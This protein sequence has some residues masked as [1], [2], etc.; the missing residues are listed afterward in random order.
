MYILYKKLML[1]I[2]LCI[3]ILLLPACATTT[4]HGRVTASNGGEQSADIDCSGKG[5]SLDGC[6]KIAAGICPDGYQIVDNKAL[7]PTGV[8]VASILPSERSQ[9]RGISIVCKGKM[10]KSKTFWLM[11]E[12]ELAGG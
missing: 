10:N 7:V 12:N 5:N 2:M 8:A 1:L 3:S 4:P 9:I 6:Y 11:E